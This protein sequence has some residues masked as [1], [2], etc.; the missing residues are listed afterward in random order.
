MKNGTG[1]KA[2]LALGGCQDAWGGDGGG[3]TDGGGNEPDAEVQNLINLD[4]PQ[5]SAGSGWTYDGAGVFFIAGGA[6]IEVTGSTTSSRLVVQGAATVTLSDATID[7]SAAGE[8]PAR[9]TPGTAQTSPSSS[10]AATQSKV[11]NDGPVSAQ[12]TTEA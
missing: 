8:S 1:K 12:T 9:Y 11:P 10:Q 7:M 3:G 6:E 2:A 5:A 4:D